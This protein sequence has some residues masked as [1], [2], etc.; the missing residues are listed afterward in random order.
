MTVIWII[1]LLLSVL[2]TS[3]SGHR[4]VTA[5]SECFPSVYGFNLT[6][7]MRDTNYTPVKD[8]ETHI[9]RPCHLPEVTQGICSTAI[10]QTQIF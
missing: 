4:V 8:G 2:L 3:R 9:E 1:A 6:T 10:N 7:C 5:R